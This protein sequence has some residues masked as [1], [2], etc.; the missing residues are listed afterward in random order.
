MSQKS[1]EPPPPGSVVSLGHSTQ[2]P[3]LYVPGPDLVAA[4]VFAARGLGPFGA[5][6]EAETAQGGHWV[7]R[8][9][10]SMDSPSVA[11]N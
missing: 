11:T 6:G 8:T 10:K 9:Q 3:R 4:G 2:Q 5:L 7:E 1:D